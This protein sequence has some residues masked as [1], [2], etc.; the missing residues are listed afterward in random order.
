MLANTGPEGK[1]VRPLEGKDKIDSRGSGYG[2]CLQD[3]A[4]GFFIFIF[5]GMLGD[6]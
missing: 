2:A 3:G 1:R 5:P 4:E 6:L